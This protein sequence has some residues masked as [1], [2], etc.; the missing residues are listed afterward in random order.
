MSTNSK[1]IVRLQDQLQ[2][3]RRLVSFD[4]YDVTI[5]QLLDMYEAGHIFV[6]PEYQRQFVWGAERQSQLIESA[7]LGIPIP[8]LFMAT[9]SDATWE[10]V[11]GV[12]RIGTLAHFV[13]TPELLKTIGRDSALQIAGL[14]KLPDLV[15][16]KFGDL[17]GPLQLMFTT[18]PIRVTVLND[19]SDMSVRF[20]LFERLNTGGI[21]LTDQEIRNCVY[22][23]PF[24]D[25][26]KECVT[27]L[28]FEN[29]IKLKPTDEKNGSKEELALRFFAFLNNYQHFDH[30]VKGFLNDYMKVR[31]QNKLT[32]EEKA[33]FKKTFEFLSA[34]LPRGII[35]GNRSVTPINLFEA[36]AVGVALCIRAKRNP[37]KGRIEKAL[38]SAELREFT[39]GAT[40]S[41]RRVAERIEFVLN[42][43]K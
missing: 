18:R 4:S 30:S 43:V 31:L 9:N 13:G 15:D 36:A 32:P 34:E 20:D 10:V 24:N 35:R 6:P 37:K 8:S 40:N 41:R 1:K 17:P 16:L 28:N 21:S 22:R 33:V 25:D 38:N 12:Q 14:E 23:G 29:V 7:F 2:K 26:L 27:D 19:K 5:K 11:D 39:T 42:A 3:E